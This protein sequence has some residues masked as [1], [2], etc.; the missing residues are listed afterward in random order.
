[1][2]I[3]VVDTNVA[4]V[5]NGRDTHASEACQLRCIEM[6]EEIRDKNVIAIDESG[7]ILDEYHKELN[8]SGQPNVGDSFYKYVFDNQL[9][10]D[11]VHRISIQRT[12]CGASFE[13][14]PDDDTL[15]GFDSDDRMFVA[16]ALAHPERPRILNAVDTN[17]ACYHAALSKHG[18][19]IEYLC[20]EHT[21][22]AERGK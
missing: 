7:C 18:V 9:V 17:W 20:P 4:V 13:E 11:R 16:V 10:P 8:F 3:W 21:A 19:R 14:F 1:M 6:L 12:T 22:P 2:T 5:A 15:E